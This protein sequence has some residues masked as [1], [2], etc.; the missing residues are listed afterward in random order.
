[1]KNSLLIIVFILIFGNSHCQE[2]APIGAEWYYHEG[3]AFSG[4]INYIKFTSEKDTLIHG[5][6][7]HKLTKRRKLLCNDRPVIEYLFTRNDTV[8]FL[9]TIFNK[10]QILYN[11]AAEKGDTWNILVRDEDFDI[12]TIQVV[13]DSLSTINI[14]EMELKRLHVTINKLDEFWH[15]SG[16]SEFI[17]KIGDPQ[18]MFYW[19]HYS[20]I[21]CD[22]NWTRGLRCYIDDEIGYYSTGIADSCTYTY[23]WTGIERKPYLTFLNVFPNPTSGMIEIRTNNDLNIDIELFTI[24]GKFI[25]ARNKIEHEVLDLTDYPDGMYLL[26]G[27]ASNQLTEI[28]KIIKY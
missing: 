8:F 10:F 16:S 22:A 7:C 5:E 15:Q 12:D 14:N 13:V 24:T 18:Y 27:R 2:F 21:A 28:L 17:E 26:I 20:Q 19:S 6:V 9:D 23:K 3:W 4:D 11:F 1:M 25:L